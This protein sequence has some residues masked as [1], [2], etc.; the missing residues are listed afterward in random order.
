MSPHFTM[1]Y[2]L[3]N[4]LESIWEIQRDIDVPHFWCIRIDG[5]NQRFPS[6]TKK[7]GERRG[8]VRSSLHKL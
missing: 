3:E 8:E 7:Q 6:Q 5:N 4:N 2:S 1:L